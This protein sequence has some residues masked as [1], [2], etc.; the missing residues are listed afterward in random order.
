MELSP[1]GWLA[2]LLPLASSVIFFALGKDLPVARRIFASA[3]GV[4]AVA[5]LP[6]TIYSTALFPDISEISGMIVMFLV[7]G[8]AGTSI[9]YSIA[10]VRARWFYY[11]L[12]VPTLAVIAGGFVLSLFL[13]SGR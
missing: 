1:L 9:F 4:F 2:F 8:I 11:L 12:H 5:I 10:S 3:H 13:L 7:G 6:A